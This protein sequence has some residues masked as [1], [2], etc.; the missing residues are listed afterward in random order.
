MQFDFLDDLI[1]EKIVLLSM[2]VVEGKID[3]IPIRQLPW[4]ILSSHLFFL[5][6]IF[7]SFQNQIEKEAKNTPSN[8]SSPK[9]PRNMKVKF[10]NSPRSR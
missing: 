1:A 8:P 2:T 5:V 4:M 10:A 9:I 6:G 7:S 3:P